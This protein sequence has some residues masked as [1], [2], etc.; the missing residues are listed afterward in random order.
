MIRTRNA[1]ACAVLRLRA[2]LSSWSRCSALNTN[3]AL[4]RRVRIAALLLPETADVC[5]LE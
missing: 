3:A 1:G 5:D 2:R 4:G